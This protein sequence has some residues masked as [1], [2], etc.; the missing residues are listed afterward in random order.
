MYLWFKD[1]LH[2]TWL[3]SICLAKKKYPLGTSNPAVLVESVPKD[4]LLYLPEKRSLRKVLIQGAWTHTVCP[5]FFML[6]SKGD[7]C[8][9]SLYFKIVYWFISIYH[10]KYSPK[11]E[12]WGFNFTYYK[13]SRGINTC[14]RHSKS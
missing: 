3:C 5:L 10:T 4:L 11:N 14:V 9:S 12:V 2:L 7:I 13:A 6:F 1:F 8:F